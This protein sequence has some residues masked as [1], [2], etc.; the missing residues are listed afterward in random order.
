MCNSNLAIETITFEKPNLQ[1]ELNKA[2]RLMDKKWQKQNTREDERS[3][4]IYSTDTVD[5][6]IEKANRYGIDVNYVLH[7]W[8]N[9]KTSDLCEELFCKYGAI[10]EQ[11]LG[12]KTI[13]IYI[14][15]IPYDVK[16]SVF[17]LALNREEFDLED[18]EDRNKLIQW[19]YTNQSNSSRKHFDNRLFVVCD[20]NDQYDNMKLKGNVELLDESIRKH[21]TYKTHYPNRLTIETDNGPREVY[22]DIVVIK[23]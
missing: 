8:Y 5:E 21:M 17:P 10:K 2:L 11:N 13:D 7:R 3:R 14:K 22:S 20:G 1:T 12:H 19:F 18:K 23:K 16:L 4:F 9:H 15:N 6:C